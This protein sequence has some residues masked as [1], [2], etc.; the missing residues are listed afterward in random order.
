MTDEN[1]YVSMKISKR[2][3]DMCIACYEN[4]KSKGL[5][6][7]QNMMFLIALIA[8]IARANDEDIILDDAFI[9][10]VRNVIDKYEK[11]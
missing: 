5:N 8:G 4:L 6:D 7:V 10:N 11:G 9:Q 1:N 3:V 2:A